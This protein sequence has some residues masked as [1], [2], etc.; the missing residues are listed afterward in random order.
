MQIYAS[1]KGGFGNV[2]FSQFAAI[3]FTIL[4]DA[5]IVTIHNIDEQEYYLQNFKHIDDDYF[6]R[7]INERINNENTI[8]DLSE[9]YV[10]VGLYQHDQIYVKYKSEIMKYI[11]DHKETKIFTS[12]YPGLYRYIN[13]IE[14]IPTKVYDIAIHIRLGDFVELGWTMN[15]IDMKNIIDM[16]P[17]QENTSVAIVTNESEKVVDC[18]YIRYI[19][20]LIP[21]A[22]LEM[23]KNP[24]IDYNILRNAKQLVCSCSTLSW[25]ASFFGRENQTVY[26]PNYKSRWNHETF[27]KPHNRVLYYDFTRSYQV[28]L[29][30]IL[31]DV[32]KIIKTDNPRILFLDTATHHKNLYAINH[33][34]N[35]QLHTIRS[36]EEFS[37]IDL[38]FYDVVFS[39]SVSIEVN[40]YPNIKFIFGPHF[41]VFPENQHMDR[42]RYNNAI[43]LQP[44]QWVVDIWQNMY[45][46]HYEVLPWG[47]NT[48]RFTEDK[49]PEEKELVF[50]Y[51]KA[52]KPEELEFLEN[53]LMER[54]ISY[55]V[56]GY[57]Q[58]Y[59]EEEY[60]ES[61]KNAKYGIW[62]DAHESQGFALEEALS[63]NVPL[64]VWNVRFMSQEH[65]SNYRDVPATT[66]PYWDERC[67]EFFY[68]PSEFAYMFDYFLEKIQKKKY[69]P[70][71]YILEHLSME[72]CENR[73]IKYIQDDITY[74]K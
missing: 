46:M 6:L 17:I 48:V 18:Q 58:R 26:F 15:P 32:R 68:S 35:I 8:I 54:N 14:S 57:R 41:S 64:L 45:P 49:P 29:W 19:Q 13:I 34:K 36:M 16:L 10:L 2:V 52:R 69:Q 9:K 71:K 33:Y 7:I 39:P 28:E 62:L 30:D 1:N 53:Q 51:Y 12:H 22:T 43:Y 25:I 37:K 27:R 60:V 65:N 66:I 67:G 56:F 59:N 72:V 11:F 55:R 73:L 63:C 4:F 24:M 5:E 38:L 74:W 42:I 20:E 23:H 61:L 40:N 44:S 21:N 47:V 31:R 70:R 50:I 3:L